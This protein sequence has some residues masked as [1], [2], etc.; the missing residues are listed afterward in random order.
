VKKGA[1]R[2]AKRAEFT[3]RFATVEVKLR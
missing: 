3:N 2:A 1:D